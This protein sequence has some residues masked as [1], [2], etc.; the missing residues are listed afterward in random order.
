MLNPIEKFN[1]AVL[2]MKILIGI[3]YNQKCPRSLQHVSYNIYWKLNN[4][5]TEG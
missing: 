5:R 3:T 2:H 4:D 1:V